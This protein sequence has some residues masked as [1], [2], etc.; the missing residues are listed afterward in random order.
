MVRN[1]DKNL[2]STTDGSQQPS[3]WKEDVSM[4]KRDAFSSKT[5][6]MGLLNRSVCSSEGKDRR[7]PKRVPR[8]HRARERIQATQR[9]SPAERQLPCEGDSGG[10]GTPW[11]T[12][13]G[14]ASTEIS[15]T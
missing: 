5:W 14:T 2:I 11:D 4:K 13:L 1:S 10:L 8:E 7:V 6:K 12:M 3:T 15:Q 9:L